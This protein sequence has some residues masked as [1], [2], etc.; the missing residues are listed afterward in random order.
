[1]Q[2]PEREWFI[3]AA[4]NVVAELT[5]ERRAQLAH[6]GQLLYGKYCG[7]DGKGIYAESFA[8]YH[9]LR[10]EHVVVTDFLEFLRCA[11]NIETGPARIQITEQLIRR[12]EAML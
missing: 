11:L 9:M 12:I 3:R 8:E 2:K 10:G 7:L 1:M 5:D 4:D 6:K